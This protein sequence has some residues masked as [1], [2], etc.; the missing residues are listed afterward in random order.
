M[1]AFQHPTLCFPTSRTT[2]LPLDM[3]RSVVKSPCRTPA[4]PMSPIASQEAYRGSDM[5][6][7]T[8]LCKF[9]LNRRSPQPVFLRYQRE[10]H[11]PLPIQLPSQFLLSLCFVDDGMVSGANPR[12]QTKPSRGIRCRRTR[13]FGWR[14]R[15]RLPNSALTMMYRRV[16]LPMSMPSHTLSDSLRWVWLIPDYLA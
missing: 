3:S 13:C 16:V 15:R 6:I 12:K 1:P 8:T 5:L 14:P 10:R 9:L 11:L 7:Q 4:N 2:A